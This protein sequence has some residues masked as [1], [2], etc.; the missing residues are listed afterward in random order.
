MMHLKSS[1]IIYSSIK[2][3]RVDILK[4]LICFK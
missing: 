4:I 2:I 3:T 1:R